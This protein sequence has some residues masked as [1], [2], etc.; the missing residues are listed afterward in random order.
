MLIHIGASMNTSPYASPLPLGPVTLKNRI[1]KSPQSTYFWAEDQSASEEVIA[2]YEALAAGGAAMV[3]IAALQLFPC[4]HG[5]K[6]GG[7]YDDRLIP[8][9]KRL[10]D[11]VRRHG[12]VS[13]AQ[14]IHD[15]ASDMERPRC[16]SAF[17]A[18]ELPCP[19]EFCSPCTGV[20]SEEIAE[21]KQTFLQ[22]AIRAK[23]AGF[24]GVEVHTANAYFLVSFLSRI[25]NRRTDE[26]GPQN[27]ENR[28]RLQREIVRD[29]RAACGED[30]LVGIRMNGQEFGH[31]QAMTIAEGV[32]AARLFAAE[33]I[34]YIS[35]T[36][37]GFGKLPM[38][39]VA[40]YWTY[41]EPDP[42]MRPH[43]DK[44][45]SGLLIPAA[46]AIKAAVNKP[47]FAGGRLDAELGQTLLERNALDGILFGRALWADAELPRKILE[48]RYTDIVRCTRC[49]TCEDPQDALPRRCRVNPAFGR[50]AELRL[51][52][53]QTPKH[54]FIVGGGPAGLEAARVAALRG[55][56]VTLCEQDSALGG[57]LRLATMVKGNQFEDVQSLTR[58]LVDSVRALPVDVRLRTHVTPD[59][60]DAA[61]PDAVVLATGGLYRLPEIPGITL[62][63]VTGVTALAARAALPLQLFGPARLHALSAWFM[64]GVGR[65]IVVLGGHI[66]GLQGALF[67]R[68]RGRRVTV[69]Q[70][71]EEIGGRMPP[72]YLRRTL[73]WLAAQGVQ[74]R[75]SVT[76][77]RIAA[78]EVVCREGEQAFCL[79]CDQVMVFTPPVSNETLSGY[80]GAPTYC[81][82]AALGVDHSLMVHAV[83]DGRAL[84]CT[85]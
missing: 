75:T 65:E 10:T 12:C 34:N 57:K 45:A 27:M 42:D 2:H 51:T 73:A 33:N 18:H 69:L 28:T 23:K 52:K 13:V 68:K 41:P 43:A 46:S 70:E 62:P 40:D 56:R 31:E 6:E 26:Y 80:S 17:A 66:E 20:S 8:G 74:I 58:R 60:L 36:G 61:H 35:V 77:Q 67:L 1:I 3:V 72:R 82:G 29:I 24:D 7:L 54:V 19:T 84:A 49:A 9:M 76:V 50:E 83:R 32:E 39:Y 44:F 47:V 79:P 53:A 63:H 55:H 4:Q 59:L 16:S 25:W 15:G 71:G 81:I 14:L 22:A 48:Q 21:M 37:Y 11:A 85:L 30:F 78:G 64:P 5:R 38:Q